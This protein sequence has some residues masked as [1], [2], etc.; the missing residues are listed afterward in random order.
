MAPQ[1]TPTGF[2][3]LAVERIMASV[4]PLGPDRRQD[5]RVQFHADAVV[6]QAGRT[7]GQVSFE[8]LSLMGAMLVGD[9]DPPTV[10][11]PIEVT[12]ISGRLQG[13]SFQ[14]EVRWA[15]LE[16][17]SVRF[18]VRILSEQI[19]LIQDIVL[20]E[21]NRVEP[22]TSGSCPVPDESADPF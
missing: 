7:L 11:A 12:A 1:H 4:V 22:D 8:N 6:S 10:G 3:S 18:G 17:R 13:A 19:R 14:A 2:P 15:V 20:D 16:A 9:I 5:P 21:L